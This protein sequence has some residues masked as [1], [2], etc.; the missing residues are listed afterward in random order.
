MTYFGV[1]FSGG[2]GSPAV[3]SDYLFAC[4]SLVTLASEDSK[5][6]LGEAVS[7]DNWAFRISILL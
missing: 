2:K 1:G 3:I 7:L 5:I 4:E 6:L